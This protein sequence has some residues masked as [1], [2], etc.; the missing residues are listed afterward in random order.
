MDSPNQCLKQIDDLLNLPNQIWFLGAGISCESGI[1]LMYPLTDRVGHILE[2]KHEKDF[3]TIRSLLPATAHVEH[4]LSHIGDLISIAKRLKSE[5]TA[6]GDEKRKITELQS[7]HSEIQRAIRDTIRWGYSPE[8][9]GTPEKVGISEN[10]IV[11]ID[12]HLRFINALFNTRRKGLERR[13][14][15][16]FFT[17]N[18]DTL[19]EDALSLCRIHSVDGF[20]GGAMAFWEPN[21]FKKP[22][23]NQTQAQ[24]TIHKLHGSIDWFISKKDVVVRRREGA[25]YPSE[26]SGRLLIYPQSTKYQ[27]T[28]KDPFASLF[29]SF[30]FALSN[31]ASS[32]LAICGY[33][34]GDEHIN[35]EIERA[36]RQRGNKLT[37]LAFVK[38]NT[39]KLTEPSLGLPAILSNWLSYDSEPWTQ[40]IVIAGSHGIFHG[41]LENQCSASAGNPH[42]W[43]SFDGV[44]QLLES[45]PEVT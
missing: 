13:P 11:S 32:L 2:T 43:W 33:S 12:P 38:Q 21:V 19:L 5:E 14:P 26:P 16:S 4:I 18:Y 27:I 10:P 41:N 45:G 29:S 20:S 23:L 31:S 40:R 22:G 35:E 25:G 30:R 34:F 36:L 17:T 7:L 39:D 8:K 3:N 28:Q 1:P 15:V 24:A 37:I 42:F 44:T 9:D 6:V